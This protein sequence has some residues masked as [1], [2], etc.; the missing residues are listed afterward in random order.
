MMRFV[1]SNSSFVARDM[2]DSWLE[3]RRDRIFN[4][5]DRELYLHLG[6]FLSWFSAVEAR[7]TLLIAMLTE[8]YN[9]DNFDL[10]ARGLQPRQKVERLR[11]LA[12]RY[13]RP[14]GP[15]FAD[16]L[17]QFEETYIPLRNSLSHNRL[18]H[19]GMT[20]KAFTITT[21]SRISEKDGGHVI[22]DLELF[23]R[24]YWLHMFQDDLGVML[25]D[26]LPK[27]R[28][29]IDDPKTPLRRAL[30]HGQPQPKKRATPGKRERKRIRKGQ[31]PRVKIPT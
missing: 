26:G 1:S 29:E 28:L 27:E 12:A 13:P 24:G 22:P 25:A 20:P 15:N 11:I 9:L 19:A 18:I 4:G 21:I 8:S 10:L 6:Y 17:G 2:S 30:N 23:E 5:E 16:V 31:P 14:I 7:I 3:R